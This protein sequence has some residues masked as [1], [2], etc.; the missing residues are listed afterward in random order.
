MGFNIREYVKTQPQ[1]AGR[2]LRETETTNGELTTELFEKHTPYEERHE[3][4]SQRNYGAFD[5]LGRQQA[6]LKYNQILHNDPNN[7]DPYGS[8]ASVSR[9]LNKPG[10]EVVAAPVLGLTGGNGSMTSGTAAATPVRVASAGRKL[11]KTN[12]N[13]DGSINSEIF[14]AHNPQSSGEYV[15]PG[16][17]PNGV[18]IGAPSAAAMAAAFG[19]KG[20]SPK[21]KVT[22]KTVAPGKKT[23]SIKK[24]KSTKRPMARKPGPKKPGPV[25]GSKNAPKAQPSANPFSKNFSWSA[26]GLDNAQ[27]RKED[28]RRFGSSKKSRKVALRDEAMKALDLF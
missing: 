16:T 28:K 14:T 17:P 1:S 23:R 27:V 26:L 8:G 12:Y 25:R 3:L 19:I 7:F 5:Q 22:T 20:S 2:R 24:T 15:A 9:I 4:P 13:G 21:A 10:S 11:T 6:T 18:A